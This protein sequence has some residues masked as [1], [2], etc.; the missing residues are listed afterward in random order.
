MADIAA[1]LNAIRT[2]ASTEYQTRIPTATRTNISSVGGPIMN[3]TPMQNEFL[4]ALVNRIALV[5]IRNKVAKN[6]L[7]TLKKGSVPLG[8]DIE[9]I[10]TNLASGQDYDPTGADL[11]TRQLPDVKAIYHRENRKGKYKVTVTRENLAKAFTSNEDMTALINSIVSTLYSGDNYDEYILMKNTM[12]AAVTGTNLITK[13]E[14]PALTDESSEKDFIKTVRTLSKMMTFPSSS[15]NA[16]LANAR[17][18]DTKA[19]TTWTPQ[20]DQVLI[21]RADVSASVDVDVLASAFNMDKASFLARKLEVD[22]FGAAADCYGILCDK[23]WVQVYDNLQEMAQFYNGEGL[24]WNYIWHHWQ[25]YSLSH[26]ANAVALV[27]ASV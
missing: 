10:F 2:T 18:G 15:Y 14:V 3:Y 19:V 11:L 20:D 21:L 7:A 6:P 25:T 13:V 23:A 17:T 9:E 16:Y 22:T 8:K 5:I 26:F 12:A 4:N 27:K 24:Y 1:I